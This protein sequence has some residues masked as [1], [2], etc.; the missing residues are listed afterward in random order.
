MAARAEN[1]PAAGSPLSRRNAHSERVRQL[2]FALEEE[3]RAVAACDLEL[4]AM[5]SSPTDAPPVPPTRS[6]RAL[7]ALTSPMYG[8][9]IAWGAQYAKVTPILQQLGLAPWLLSVAWLAGPVSGLVV[10]PLVGQ[11]SDRTHSESRFFPGKRRL[12]MW[13]GMLG[14]SL[15]SITMAF[16]PNIGLLLGDPDDAA[17]L[18]E[19]ALPETGSGAAHALP[20]A[21]LG[22]LLNGEL[23]ATLS[24]GGGY[25]PAALWVAIASFWAADFF[26]NAL[27]GPARTL[28]VSGFFF[29]SLDWSS[30]FAPGETN[31]LVDAHVLPGRRALFADC[32]A[33]FAF[34]IAA[35][36]ATQLANQLSFVEPP[37]HPRALATPLTANPLRPLIDSLRRIPSMPRSRSTRCGLQTR[38]CVGSREDTY[39][40]EWSQLPSAISHVRSTWHVRATFATLFSMFVGWFI[41]WMYLP[42]FMGGSVYGMTLASLVTLVFLC[43][44]LMHTLLLILLGTSIATPGPAIAAIAA[45]GLPFAGRRPIMPRF[46]VI[47]YAIVGR[48]A[49]ESSGAG[50][51]GRH[52]TR[53]GQYMATMNLF[54]C[55]PE[56]LVS[57]VIG[58]AASASGSMRLPL[59]V[60]SVW[61]AVAAA[62]IHTYLV[63][64]TPQQ[65][66]ASCKRYVKNKAAAAKKRAAGE[67]DG[68]ELLAQKAA[69]DAGAWTVAR[70][71]G[72]SPKAED[73]PP[74]WVRPAGA[75]DDW[76]ET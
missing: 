56:L 11:V 5:E 55:L 49:A 22:E 26:L 15:S 46:L 34:S 75:P 17:L 45:L 38:D 74:A 47:P 71:E 57:L 18:A 48:A 40:V 50:V 2:R 8:I 66:R 25:H 16:S 64:T 33:I 36:A 73:H 51:D 31:L 43:L 14:L 12:W 28:V 20:P 52:W 65:R 29:G 68:A 63:R 7:L 59:L 1:E 30:F 27:Q 32:R 62:V 35:M 58:P 61:C 72:E 76:A 6:V 69:A 41:T 39:S 54:L 23:E 44:E 19:T 70:G 37:P 4:Q 60:G 3:E 13:C 67:G 10:Q 53:A 21:E 9:G 42:A 24:E